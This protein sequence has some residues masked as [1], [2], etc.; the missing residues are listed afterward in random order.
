MS[1]I[2]CLSCGNQIPRHIPHSAK[3]TKQTRRR[4]YNCSPVRV[5]HSG[6][7]SERRKR[8]ETLVKMLGGRCSK[9]GYD[10]SIRGLSFHHKDPSTKSFD[11]SSNGHLLD[12][13]E[14]VLKEVRKCKLLCLNCHAEL[15]NK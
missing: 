2:H 10:K 1:K 13:W 12:D 14:L 8:K 11:I 4:C 3:K 6:S 7:K 15:H 5:K 9:C